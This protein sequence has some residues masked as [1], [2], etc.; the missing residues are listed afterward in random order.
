[1]IIKECVFT[2]NRTFLQIIRDLIYIYFFLVE[3][4]TSKI[5]F[6]SRKTWKC[7]DSKGDESIA[8]SYVYKN[9]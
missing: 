4:A 8:I 5:L 6:K 9:T 3:A 7:S 2:S 1:M